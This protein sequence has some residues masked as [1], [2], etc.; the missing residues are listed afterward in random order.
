M[1][2]I[3]LHPFFVSRPPR[4]IPG[5]QF[6]SPPSLTE[7][8]RP[9]N[10]PAEIDPDIMGNL[11]TLW[12]GASDDEIVAALMSRD[13][14]WEK[15][16]YH[17]LIKYRNKH[18]E[19]YN[20]DDEEDAEARARRQARRQAS[21]SGPSPAKRKGT[22]PQIAQKPK[23][24][25]LG[26]NETIQ[27]RIP[28]H[29]PQA[30]T[31]KKAAGVPD[32]PATTKR[33]STL[34]APP[35]RSP[36]G[37]R[38]PMSPR[39]GSAAS[40]DATGAHTPAI[41]LQEATPTKEMLPPP[42]PSP[43][44]R[45]RSEIITTP[46]M[47][48]SAQLGPLNVP[49]VQDSQLQH[50][51]NEVAS[52]LNT[53]NIRSSVASGS[54]SS[55]AILGTDYQAYLAYA[56]GGV[57]PSS[58]AVTAVEVDPN[59]FADADDDDTEVASLHSN[60]SP[61]I[62]AGQTSPLIGLGIGA[63]PAHGA[64]PG[65]Y[66]ITTGNNRWSYASSAGSSHRGTSATSYGEPIISPG[67]YSPNPM[68]WAEQSHHQPLQAQRAAPLPPPRGAS[69]L[70][71]TRPAP[72][73]PARPLSV[74]TTLPR[75]ESYVVLDAA[76]QTPVD[77]TTASWGSKTS[78]FGAHRAQDGFGMLKKKKA[79]PQPID[80]GTGLGFTLEPPLTSA[81]AGVSPSPKRSWFNNLFSFRPAS[82]TLLSHDNIGNTRDRTKKLLSDMGVQVMTVEI[83]GLRA[84]K[85]RY[86]DY[87]GES[88]CLAASVLAY[89]S[90]GV[91]SVRFRI[92]FSRSTQNTSGGYN[93]LVSLTQE[94]G[95]QSSFKC[96]FLHASRSEPALTG[97][98]IFQQLRDAIE[99]T[100]LPRPSPVSATQSLNTRPGTTGPQLLSAPSTRL[101]VSAPTTPVLQSSPR[102]PSPQQ[103]NAPGSAQLPVAIRM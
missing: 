10:S 54:S 51:F 52:Q 3:L 34:S 31:P 90:D 27:E 41:I 81:N 100:S 26:E 6:V 36:A 39:N 4:P 25:P 13:K 68:V 67:L 97:S 40:T 69:R 14:T 1:P 87:R 63:A 96:Q 23:L 42:L 88:T 49:Q 80:L 11:K 57:P 22:A 60:V 58:P 89:E 55:S 83:D 29:R 91:K 61:S 56:N 71:P 48:D 102:F 84:L 46:N 53:M 94:K 30:P 59:Q 93:T 24:A 43:S 2:D 38:P 21:S 45:P 5:R 85:C 66:P 12:H 103:M 20:M 99:G 62:H 92:E 72:L 47:M 18:L 32:S 35:P 73:A 64:R 75:D 44:P 9:V 33:Q 16:I 15:A 37:P 101:A 76:D 7:V 74:A 95:A 86:E 78:G 28:V 98:A 79:K 17:L 82:C 65:L 19:N 77:P 8:E 70:A 50:F